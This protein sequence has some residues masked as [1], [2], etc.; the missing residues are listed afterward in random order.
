VLD[1]L[2][3][4]LKEGFSCSLDILYRGLGI[5]KYKNIFS[6]CTFFKLLVIKTLDP[7]GIQPKMLD[8]DPESMKPDPKQ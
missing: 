1:V 2:F 4:G 7:V 6:S 5:S 8:P 3:L